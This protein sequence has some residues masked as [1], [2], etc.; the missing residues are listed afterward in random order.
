MFFSGWVVES[1][2][3]NK[4]L[5]KGFRKGCERRVI[6]FTVDLAALPYD[7]QRSERAYCARGNERTMRG[8]SE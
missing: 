7:W 5:A 4:F 1:A 8:N 2:H 3:Y 6:L